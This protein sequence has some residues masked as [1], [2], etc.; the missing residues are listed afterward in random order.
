MRSQ[1]LIIPTVLVAVLSA[2]AASASELERLDLLFGTEG[3]VPPAATPEAELRTFV[4]DRLTQD[5]FYKTVMPRL[6]SVFSEDAN[7]NGAFAFTLAHAQ[8]RGRTVY[9]INN[10]TLGR[11]APPCADTNWD[12]HY[13]NLQRQRE[14]MNVCEPGLRYL[15]EQLDVRRGSD[16]RAL[17]E[18]AG[19]VLSSELGRFPIL[20]EFQGKDHLPELPAILIG[21]GI[22]P[23]QYGETDRKM[24]ATPL[25]AR[26]GRPAHGRGD[27]VPTIDDLGATLLQWFGIDDSGSLG[28]TGRR[29]DFLFS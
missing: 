6:F 23:G 12:T 2:H 14:A 7:F 9:F 13:F 3:P 18:S 24:V 8:V 16:G 26:T 27:F 28:Y 15:L 17:S 4:R 10:A 1:A 21:P 29:L 22:R 5:A 25:S 11:K 19:V 20:N